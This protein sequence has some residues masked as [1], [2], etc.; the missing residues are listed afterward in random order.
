MGAAAT[1]KPGFSPTCDPAPP[2]S[3]WMPFFLP[4]QGMRWP[5]PS[6]SKDLAREPFP[7]GPW[8]Q[9][10]VSGCGVFQH[11]VSGCLCLGNQH[12][13]GMGRELRRMWDT[14][15]AVADSYGGTPGLGLGST[16]CTAAG[17]L[18]P[19]YLFSSA[20]WVSSVRDTAMLLREA[21]GTWEDPAACPVTGGWGERGCVFGCR[22]CGSG[23]F[24]LLGGLCRRS[25]PP[26][27][28]PSKGLCAPRV[29]LSPPV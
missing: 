18:S 28:D 27:S 15:L 7:E 26:A 17:S 6:P 12:I 1:A 10:D 4:T 14:T 22:C 21:C 3:L 2:A 16:P 29:C 19:G 24:D 5:Q 9:W 20:V 25:S 13:P 23:V 11:G 8:Q